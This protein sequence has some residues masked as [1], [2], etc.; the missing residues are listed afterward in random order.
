MK[1]IFAIALAM[2]MVLS[3]A[4]A[5]ALNDCF[6]GKFDWTC[7]SD[8]TNC[9]KAS[10]KVIPYVKVNDACG[11]YAWQVSDCASAI[12]SE[13]VYWAVELTVEAYPDNEWWAAVSSTES[14]AMD[15]EG[16]AA[17]DEVLGLPVIDR[18]WDED[19]VFMYQF[20]NG[21]G[22]VDVED[23]DY[24]FGDD[25]VAF[26]RVTDADEVEVCATITSEHSGYGEW[27]FGDYTV[28][29]EDGSLLITGKCDARFGMA[30]ADE[31]VVDIGASSAAFL[32]EVKSVFN[33]TG[34]VIGT[35]VDD[36]IIQAN[37]GWDDEFESCFAWSDKGASVVN[38][39]CVVAIPKTGDASVLAW[40]F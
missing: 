22:W 3:M 5:F 34:C 18:S 26:S 37:F 12:N 23:E 6:A 7:S 17:A 2:V 15:Y 1:K 31:E 8:P 9:G 25:F 32:E 27:E 28:E 13:N 19:H 36:D 29:V 10:V 14:V 11:G 16:I 30:W 40:L 35:C 21:R 24:D 20:N 4:S 39:E 33:L 38:P